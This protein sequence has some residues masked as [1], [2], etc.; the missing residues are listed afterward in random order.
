MNQTTA[1]LSVF[2][3]QCREGQ[4][5]WFSQLLMLQVMGENRFYIPERPVDVLTLQYFIF[6]LCLR[7]YEKSMC[8]IVPRGILEDTQNYTKNQKD[9]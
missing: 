9:I 2:E 8:D 6:T 4:Q 3:P 5:G 1:S 7:N